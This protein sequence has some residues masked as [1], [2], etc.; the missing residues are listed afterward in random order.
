MADVFL[1]YKR[2]TK[3][4]IKALAD[5][6]GVLQISVWYDTA[7]L[8][9]HHQDFRKSIYQAIDDAKA[10]IVCF[11][12]A[13]FDGE[14]D[15]GW[16]IEEAERAKSAGKLVATTLE[17]FSLGPPFKHHESV[18]LHHW[19]SM[20]DAAH[21]L[22]RCGT[23]DDPEWLRVLRSLGHFL[24]RADLEIA[25]TL[26]AKKDVNGAAKWAIEHPNDPVAPSL[27]TIVSATLN[28]ETLRIIGLRRDGS[29]FT[30]QMDTSHDSKSKD[31]TP[32]QSTS[33][34]IP[35]PEE[36]ANW[37]VIKDSIDP[38]DFSEHFLKWPLGRYALICREK[39]EVK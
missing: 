29:T 32:Q 10:A 20:T 1:S 19:F 22:W 37:N 11:T 9:P 30:Q 28:E 35:D 33:A 23:W 38:R 21:D 3:A 17:N 26:I 8:L 4:R 12:P 15:G 39:G 18:S 5:Q 7:Q 25:A 2:G 31:I 16:V 36:E 34:P 6:L 24:G 13:C 14:K 27:V